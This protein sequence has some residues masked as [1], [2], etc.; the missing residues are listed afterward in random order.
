MRAAHRLSMKV[1][2][3]FWGGRGRFRSLQGISFRPGRKMRFS[4]RWRKMSPRRKRQ[5]NRQDVLPLGRL[6]SPSGREQR[7]AWLL[8]GRRPVRLRRFRVSALPRARG[9]R[10]CPAFPQC[11]RAARAEATPSGCGAASGSPRRTA[12]SPPAAQRCQ[13]PRAERGRG[14]GYPA[15]LPPRSGR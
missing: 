1:L 10:F 2:L 8:P 6:L 9:R 15:E 5:W 12:P 13:S 4:L 14:T 11:G 3:C 7:R